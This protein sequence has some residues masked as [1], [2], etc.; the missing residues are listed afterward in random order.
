MILVQRKYI[1]RCENQRSSVKQEST[2]MSE[3]SKG[4]NILRTLGTL[5]EGDEWVGMRLKGRVLSRDRQA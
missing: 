3:W 1:K 5:G 4:T 2:E